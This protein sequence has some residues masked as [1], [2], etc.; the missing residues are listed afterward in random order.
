VRCGI[1]RALLFAE[2]MWT[3]SE[4]SLCGHTCY[5]FHKIPHFH[6]KA[7]LFPPNAS[8]IAPAN[9][10]IFTNNNDTGIVMDLNAA[11]GGLS[12]TL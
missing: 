4:E 5:R 7:S 8:P 11:G 2:G 12:I 1:H 3:D 10:S 9:M 6:I